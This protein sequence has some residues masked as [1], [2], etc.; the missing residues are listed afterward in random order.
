M[1]LR[2]SSAPIPTSLIPHSREPCSP[3]PERVLQFSRTTSFATPTQNMA[4]SSDYHSPTKHDNK[5]SSYCIPR[6]NGL[7]SQHGTKIKESDPVGEPQH[8]IQCTTKWKPSIREL[9][10]SSGLDR[11]VLVEYDEDGGE[12]K[13]RESRGLQTLVVGGG[14]GSDGGK[15]CGGH[16]SGWESDK[17]DAYYQAMIQSNPNNALLL[18]NYAKFLK[19]VRGDYPKAEE[20]LERAILANPGDA[21]V[22]SIYADLIWQIEKD[23]DRAEGYFEQAVKS[24]PDDCYVLAS[25]AKFLWDAEEEDDKEHQHQTDHSNVLSGANGHRHLNAYLSVSE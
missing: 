15:I 21:T 8:E 14:M 17:T 20:Y 3:E 2:S 1:L 4:D 12:E 11:Q 10:S 19:E 13:K 6:S 22:L 25:Y 16:G 9:F 23:A 5:N 24:A 7:Q 18:G